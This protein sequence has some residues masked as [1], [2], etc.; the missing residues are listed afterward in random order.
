MN[1][2]LSGIIAICAFT[3][4]VWAIIMIVS[5][6]YAYFSGASRAEYLKAEKGIAMNWYSASWLPESVFIDAKV[7]ESNGGGE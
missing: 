6:P 4:G 2:L 7:R 1:K 5:L 3:I